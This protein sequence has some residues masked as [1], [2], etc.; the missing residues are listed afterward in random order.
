MIAWPHA[1]SDAVAASECRFTFTNV[2][3]FL[4]PLWWDLR[5]LDFASCDSF[6]FVYLNSVAYDVYIG[7]LNCHPCFIIHFFSF[8]LT[9]NIQV[10]PH[11]QHLSL[12][13][14]FWFQFDSFQCKRTY[15][16]S[17][18]QHNNQVRL[19]HVVDDLQSRNITLV[20]VL[21]CNVNVFC[22]QYS[23]LIR[24]NN[25]KKERS[26]LT[27]FICKCDSSCVMSLLYYV[28]IGWFCFVSFTKETA[29]IIIT[30]CSFSFKTNWDW[31]CARGFG[32][33]SV[34]NWRIP[35]N[36]AVKRDVYLLALTSHI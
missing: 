7:W 24:L 36:K 20:L 16:E 14:L 19:A 22:T 9:C 8:M 12:L 4:L 17:I 6:R 18:K 11:L 15:S 25:L 23:L 21:F 2:R 10:P 1:S 26:E 31:H 29:I 32:L 3:W 5:I 30:L 34:T 27:Q 33:K 28:S 35:N 13:D